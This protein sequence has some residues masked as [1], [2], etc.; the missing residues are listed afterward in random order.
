M[1][2]RSNI[3]K[4]P[5]I[6]PRVAY[7]AALLEEVKDLVERQWGPTASPIVGRIVVDA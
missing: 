2:N 6:R 3:E 5:G 4:L 1:R 7:N